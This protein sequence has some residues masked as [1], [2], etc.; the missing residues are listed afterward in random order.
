MSDTPLKS[1]WGLV[2]GQAATKLLLRW[3]NPHQH[4]S[5]SQGQFA[6]HRG[7]PLLS[8]RF[9]SIISSFSRPKAKSWPT[10]KLNRARP[11]D[12]ASRAQARSADFHAASVPFPREILHCHRACPLWR[13]DGIRRLVPRFSH[14]TAPKGAMPGVAAKIMSFHATKARQSRRETTG[15]GMPPREVVKITG[16][17]CAPANRLGW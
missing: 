11:R 8:E 16:G 7:K 6:R 15:A 3:T 5:I 12:Q 13:G 14:F 4:V 10:P 17:N 1:D 2:R 9:D